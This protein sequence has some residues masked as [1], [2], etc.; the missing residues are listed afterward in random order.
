[1]QADSGEAEL[2]L[3]GNRLVVRGEL[4]P[5]DEKRYADAL[6]AYLT[7]GGKEWVLDFTDLD[8]MSSAYVGSTALFSRVARQGGGTMVILANKKVAHILAL[9]GLDKIVDVRTVD[10]GDG[11]D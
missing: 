2:F 9:A 10:P 3:D 1:M 4:G 7:S 5:H 6:Y 11:A 8:Y